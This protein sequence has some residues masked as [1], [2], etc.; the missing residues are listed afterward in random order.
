VTQQPNPNERLQVVFEDVT[1]RYPRGTDDVLR[2]VELGIRENEF[3][4]IVGRTGAGKTTLLSMVNGLIPHFFEGEIA[5]RVLSAGIDTQRSPATTMARVV[6]MVFQDAETQILANTV[7]KDIA[8]GPSNLGQDAETMKRNIAAALERTDLCGYERRSPSGLSGG[9]K[10][11]VA[12]AGVLAMEPPIL[13]LDEPTSE[14]DPEASAH[15]FTLCDR[16][17]TE[18]RMTL[19]LASHEAER[20]LDHAKRIIVI[21]EGTICWDGDPRSLYS[22]VGA[23]HHRGISVP[24]IAELMWN[25]R[26]RGIRIDDPLPLTLDE[27]VPVVA[28]LFSGSKKNIASITSSAPRPAQRRVLI[29][30]RSLSHHYNGTRD[31]L[32]GIDLQIARGE[33]IALVGKNGAG[34]TTLAK[35]FNG[36]LKPTA[37]KVIVS[38]KD[39][40]RYSIGTLSKTVGY[41]FQNPDHQIFCPSVREEVE[42][43][44]RT[45]EGLTESEIASR[46]AEALRAVGLEDRSARHPF[47]LGK[48]ERQK[49]AVASVLARA[50]EVLVIDEPT[51][52]LDREDGRA[53]MAMIRRLHRDGH[54]II[55]ITHDMQ[56]AAD[57][58]E[59]VI[60]LAHGSILADGTPEEIFL[61]PDL[62]HRAGLTMPPV[63][64]L[65]LA[66]HAKGIDLRCVAM[67]RFEEFVY[68]QHNAGAANAR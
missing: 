30:V 16:L 26:Q 19:L 42:F 45:M 6:G 65:S 17:C 48:G 64:A 3:V 33:F 53:M 54:T 1:Y 66:L 52:G 62:L 51:T 15:L 44:L 68:D 5:G 2:R 20:L 57:H 34:K 35:H 49:L 60:V 43:G 8:F 14:L 11:R 40:N 46:T 28:G 47:T 24:V 59:R 13:V 36:L 58:A 31:A 12:I 50:P 7:E 27:A 9:E 25:L 63:A 32:N 18:Q 67:N 10:Q 38:G 41:V 37:G 29:D 21:E 55:V 56:L 4:A 22:D 23:C 39:T 61:Q